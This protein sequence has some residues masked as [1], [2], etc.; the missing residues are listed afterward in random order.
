MR[1]LATTGPFR[2]LLSKILSP[3][4]V[5]MKNSRF[6]PS[7]L[8]VNVPLCYLTTTGRKSGESRMT[9]LLF[10]ET[11]RGY[12]VAATNFGTAHHPGWSYNLDADP[13]ATIEIDGTSTPVVADRMP[14]EKA[15][16]IWEQ[17]C[18]VWP[19]YET[20]RETTDRDVRV[21]EL[22]PTG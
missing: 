17:L 20:Y 4:D 3:L 1:R 16:A 5:R 14:A 9:P 21:Y 18:Q 13:H 2:W 11:D 7:R 8:G 19:A 15:E 22:I 12:A 6:A 10:I